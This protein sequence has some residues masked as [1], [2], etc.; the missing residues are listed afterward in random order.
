MSITEDVIRK[1]ADLAH[2]EIT[3]EEQTLYAKQLSS[4]LEYVSQL[5]EVPTEGIEPMVTAT[6]MTFTFREDVAEPCG[7]LEMMTTNA[8]DRQGNLFRVPPIL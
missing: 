8:P 4:V 7:D 5:K 1:T 6:D 2:L 3:P